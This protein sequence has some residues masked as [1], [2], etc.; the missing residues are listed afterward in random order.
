MTKITRVGTIQRH[1]VFRP[2]DISWDS[3]R[4]FLKVAERGSV[5]AVAMETGM[6]ANTVRRLLAGLEREAGALLLERSA[7]GVKL[8]D[9]GRE[10]FGAGRAMLQHAQAVARMCHG[11]MPGA[12]APVR[13][14][15]TEGLGAFWLVPR[16][17]DLYR[18]R[19]GIQVDLRCSMARPDL[20]GLEVDIAVQLDPPEGEDLVVA[21]LG[22]LHIVM[23]A[24]RD[25]VARHGQLAS[26][27]DLA[28]HQIIEFVAPQVSVE[29]LRRE[30]SQQTLRTNVGLRVNT[31]SAQV[32]AATHGAGVTALPT[33]APLV[34]H[35]LVQVAPDLQVVRNIWLAYHPKAAK[36][37]QVR[38]TIDWIKQAFDAR[39]CPWF[40]PAFM[41]PQSIEEHMRHRGLL[42]TF[43]GFRE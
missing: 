23:F 26:K 43:A 8:T 6:A 1:A 17:M 2:D 16:L 28:H 14:G 34:T 22:W 18:E 19:P 10:M 31:S 38:Q 40:G 42:Q 33:Y 37:P 25:Y 41:S 12:R 35:N 32:L 7:R 15:V 27:A 13:V 21:R 29:S 5:R 3:I 30:M 24:S 9:H 36:L 11:R 4:L 39:L 20:A